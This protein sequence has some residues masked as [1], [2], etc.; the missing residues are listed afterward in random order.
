MTKNAI[1][2][3]DVKKAYISYD[4]KGIL[5]VKKIIVQALRGIS[6]SIEKNQVFGLLGPN[7]AGKTTTVKIISTLL[8]PDEGYVKV[9]GFDTVE[10]C[11]EVRKLLGVS[12]SVNKGFYWKL[13]GRENLKY[14]GLLY[15]LD[16]GELEKRLDEV[17]DTVG[18]KDLGAEN[19]LWEEYSLG[20][21]ARLSLARALLTDPPIIILDEPTLGLDPPSAKSLRKMLK[22]LAHDQDKTVLV[23]THNMFEAEIIADKLAIIDNG[24]IIALGTVNELK[25]MVKGEISIEVNFLMSSNHQKIALEETL[26]SKLNI[27][28]KIIEEERGLSLKTSVSDSESDDILS[29]ILKTIND[30]NGKIYNV[31]VHQ[32]NLEDVF[33]KITG[34]R[35][36]K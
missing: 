2:V 27:P 35:G 5:K 19:K 13:T 7:G 25:R 30:F 29:V 1:E 21:K 24:K 22:T 32:P 14:F 28:I 33:I 36:F 34:R 26:L 31:R 11:V 6:F 9:F 17:L 15:G 18:L 8:V 10:Q 16:G 12:L 4:R 20:M 23:T 3:H